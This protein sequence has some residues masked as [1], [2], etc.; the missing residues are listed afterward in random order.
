MDYKEENDKESEEERDK[1]DA[2]KA[3]KLT[4]N[5]SL[6]ARKS[7]VTLIT[8]LESPVRILIIRKS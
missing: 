2:I 4:R 1:S 8:V 7:A 3:M 6:A 5:S